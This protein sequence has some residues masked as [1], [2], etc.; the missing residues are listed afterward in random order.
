MDIVGLM[1]LLIFVLT[2]VSV[3]FALNSQAIRM[4]SRVKLQDAFEAVG[5]ESLVDDFVEKAESLML[6]CDTFRLI[7]SLG[8]LARLPKTIVKTIMLNNGRNMA[9][10]NPRT[11][12]L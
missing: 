11:V 3:F 2:V 8:I 12:C 7:A 5:D 4:F 9:Q 1:V 10:A 6:S